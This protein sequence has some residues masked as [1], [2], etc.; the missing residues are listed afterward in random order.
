MMIKQTMKWL[1]FFITLTLSQITLADPHTIISNYS[2]L[3][4][5][6]AKGNSVRALMTLN[7]CVSSSH[8]INSNDTLGGMNFTNF[9]KYQISIDGQ[10]KNII[11]TSINMLIEHSKLGTIYNYVRLRIFED[12][13]AEVF[14]EYLDPKT[15]VQ[16]GSASFNCHLSDGKDKNGIVL[17]D[18]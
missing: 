3:L 4:A 18:L 1:V 17:Y 7:K 12:N 9:N 10:Q 15:Y 16:L 13:S 8:S 5:A 6:L 2:D 11:A 14:S